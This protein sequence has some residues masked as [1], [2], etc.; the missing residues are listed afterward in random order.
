MKGDEGAA[1]HFWKDCAWSGSM[2]S[3]WI[4]LE[5]FEDETKTKGE[6]LR[7]ERADLGTLCAKMVI[8]TTVMI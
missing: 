3:K 2:A 8:E 5:T 7:T 1:L 6:E 4:G